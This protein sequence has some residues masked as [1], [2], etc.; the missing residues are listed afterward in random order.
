MRNQSRLFE[1][2]FAEDVLLRVTYVWKR[3]CVSRFM[4]SSKRKDEGVRTSGKMSNKISAALIRS[5]L[6]RRTISSHRVKAKS[7]FLYRLA[8]MEHCLAI[9]RSRSR[10]HRNS[11]GTS[12]ESVFC[13]G[14]GGVEWLKG[15]ALASILY[16][17]GSWV[18]GVKGTDG[19]FIER[20]P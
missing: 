13:A 9:S 12:A 1:G 2:V 3:E 6:C 16:F 7:V 15:V 10:Q 14:C 5:A 17:L 18:G 19:S 11:K 8:L 20:R 4:W